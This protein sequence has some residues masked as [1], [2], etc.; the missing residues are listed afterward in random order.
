[1]TKLVLRVSKFPLLLPEGYL[2]YLVRIRLSAVR[3]KL[4]NYKIGNVDV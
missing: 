4:R 1:V 2:G 3:C